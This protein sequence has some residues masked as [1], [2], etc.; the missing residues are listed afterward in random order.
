MKY[1]RNTTEFYIEEPTVLTMGKFD[2]LHMGHKYLLEFLFEEKRKGF[3]TA[4]F[5]F[6]MPPKE[7]INGEP[8]PVLTTIPEKESVFEA[9]GIDYLIEC[10]F[11]DEIRNMD[12]ET[13]LR[14]IVRQLN[15]KSI[16]AGD[17]FHF[18]RNRAGDYELLQRMSTELGYAF[19][20]VTKMKHRGRDISS[21]Y[22]REEVISGNLEL[23]NYLLGYPFFIMGQ[24]VGGKKI[25]RT[26]NIPTIN[27]YPP[28]E[29]LLPPYGVYTAEVSYRGKTY[30][31]IANIGR[32]PTIEGENPVGVETHIFDFDEE[33]YGESVKVGLLKYLREEKKFESIT[34]LKEQIERDM[35]NAKDFLL[36][37]KQT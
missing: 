36:K 23:V 18:G 27:V 37:G 1:I 4:I 26:M 24:V 17:D 25:G 22:I 35:E 34:Q 16:V 2:G 5:T 8:M 33:I 9:C 11:T 7:K 30:G 14:K 6:D 19:H 15:V 13:F 21:T 31:G 12:A 32:K 29:K 28:K 20:V 3:K 10:P